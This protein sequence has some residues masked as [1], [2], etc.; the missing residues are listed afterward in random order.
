VYRSSE[1][2]HRCSRLQQYKQHPEPSR[3]LQ[4][5]AARIPKDGR[6]CSGFVTNSVDV[7]TLPR[8][9]ILHIFHEAIN[10]FIVDCSTAFNR[11][12]EQVDIDP[13]P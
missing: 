10:A 7:T 3:N 6:D 4:V 9:N 13:S 5:S 11:L 2:D 12:R 8:Q 1:A